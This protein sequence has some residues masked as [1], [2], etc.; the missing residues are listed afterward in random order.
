MSSRG[1]L[2]V[3]AAPAGTGKSTIISRLR[4]RHSD[5]GFSCSAT[6]RSPRP[7]EQDGREYFFLDR[8][9]FLRRVACGDFFEHEEVHGELYGTLRTPT[10]ERLARGET[11]I[12]DLDVK[13]ALTFKAGFPA[14]LTIFL[15]PPSRAT[16][17]ER[18][19]KRHTEPPELIERRLNRVEMEIQHADRFDCRVINDDLERAVAEI[20]AIVSARFSG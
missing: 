5:W 14:A 15:Q 13:G 17:R 6:T 12:F 10:L 20:E 16:L 8:D 19:E 18:L 2:L 7:G 3:F 9:E 11:L 1:R 4:E